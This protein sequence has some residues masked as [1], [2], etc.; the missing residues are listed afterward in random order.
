MTVSFLNL[1]M[2]GMMA[3][4]DTR[5]VDPM[6]LANPLA[7]RMPQIENGR[8]GHDK[9]L[10]LEWQMADSSV[11]VPF[12]PSY[13]D[14]EEVTEIRSILYTED[15]VEL[16]HVYRE[17]MSVH[18]FWDNI[19]YSLTTSRT[20]KFSDDLD[21]YEGVQPMPDAQIVWPQTAHK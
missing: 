8:P 13:I 20:L 18:R 19:K 6:G 17:P 2:T 3:P 5:V 9:Y 1:G 21:D 14:G 4:L 10:P 15:F 16:F 12:L 7:A 11:F